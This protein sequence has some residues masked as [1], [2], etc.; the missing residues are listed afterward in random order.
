MKE[1]GSKETRGFMIQCKDGEDN[2]SRRRAISFWSQR[3]KGGIQC[4][5]QRDS[6][7]EDRGS[8]KK[9]I[10]YSFYFLRIVAG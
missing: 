9:N 6:E 4:T 7:E 2:I 8:K 1:Q 5:A 3:L 10:S